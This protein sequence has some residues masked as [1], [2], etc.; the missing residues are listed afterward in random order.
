MDQPPKNIPKEKFPVKI[1]FYILGLVVLLELI[2]GLKVLSSS[3]TAPTQS[4]QTPLPSASSPLS[5]IDV[6]SSKKQYRVGEEIIVSINVD[7]AG[8]KTDGTDLVL[9][10][11]PKILE[12]SSGA[13][14]KGS[15][16]GEYPVAEVDSKY[17][18]IKVSGVSKIGQDGFSGKG[19]LAILNFK[20]KAAGKTSLKIDF[21]A[22]RTTDSNIVETKTATDILGLVNNLDLT[23]TP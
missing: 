10:F 4:Y 6:L 17:G 5:R 14:K 19:D 20:A 16:Y 8:K 15:I 12:A 13:I 1:V 11:D 3:K 23:I 9:N 7:T 18:V 2:I 21:T 22:G